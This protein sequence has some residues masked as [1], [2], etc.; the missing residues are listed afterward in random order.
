MHREDVCIR[1]SQE[2]VHPRTAN[3]D[4]FHTLCTDCG[5]TLQDD[6]SIQCPVCY[7]ETKVPESGIAELP[8]NWS[9]AFRNLMV[10]QQGDTSLCQVCESSHTADFYCNDC[11]QWLCSIAHAV[12]KR[13]RV[14]MHHAVQD[15]E[16]MRATW[17]PEA[18][19]SRCSRHASQVADRYCF[20]CQD[21]LCIYCLPKHQRHDV[22]PKLGAWPHL[23]EKLTHLLSKANTCT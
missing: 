9:T 23:H 2:L 3:L 6:P 10:A 18:A 1:C 12:H 17:T 16:T 5:K 8:L 22:R 19:A 11:D 21:F 15:A 14:T 13:T 4:C 20:P 7:R